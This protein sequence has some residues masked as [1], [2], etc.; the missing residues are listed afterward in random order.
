MQTHKTHALITYH[1]LCR[2]RDV[3]QEA[4]AWMWIQTRPRHWWHFHNTGNEQYDE[5]ILR[6]T[7]FRGSALRLILFYFVSFQFICLITNAN[8]VVWSCV[9]NALHNLEIVII[10]VA[11]YRTAIHIEQLQVT[12]LIIYRVSVHA[13]WVNNLIEW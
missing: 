11:I 3:V 2:V 4:S 5:I 1:A 7:M 12:D 9:A 8:E 13:Q 10:F 6:W